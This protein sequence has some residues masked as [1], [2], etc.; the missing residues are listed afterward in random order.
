[1]NVEELSGRLP[2]LAR[3][4][5]VP[6]GQFALHHKGE[7]RSF[8]FGEQDAAG[9]VPVTGDAK[10]PVG[11]ITKAF[12]AALAML[13]VDEGDLD[14]DAPVA[15]VLTEL[16]APDARFGAATT[17]R[18]LLSH[19]GGL[20]PGRDS[21]SL[22]GA[23]RR[24]YLADCARMAPIDTFG[25]S[26]SYSNVGYT[27]IGMLAEQAVRMD[28]REALESFLLDPLDIEPAYIA[29]P[30]A[31]PYVSGHAART[32]P[33]RAVPVRQTLPAIEAPAGALAL[34][35]LDLLAFGLLHT[36][37]ADGVPGLLDADALAGM[38][39]GVPGAE[40]FGLAD[41]WGLGLSLYRADDGTH[42]TGHDGTADGTSC[43]LRVD[44]AGGTVVALTTNAHTGMA[45][46]E[47][48]L[49]DLR[50]L[51]LDVAS[52]SYSA[53]R[54]PREKIPAPPGCLGRYVNGETEYLVGPGGADGNGDEL[55]LRLD[56]EPFA[57]ITV[58]EGL[59]FTLREF[60]EGGMVY[61]GR[62]LRNPATGG[63]DQIQVTGRRAQRV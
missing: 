31:R 26:F 11:S 5:G 16:R 49:A 61:L 14:L 8:V 38:R 51:G 34:S 46:W 17:L 55:T 33:A 20:P 62:F 48:L 29:G 15:E 25:S 35:A 41:G 1:M 27:V 28:W 47:S 59:E 39:A 54:D 22:A 6:G 63:I 40:P 10:F 23:T 19:S 44:P 12:T 42:W 24:G 9:T 45:M 53:F 7:T 58:H 50:Q 52:Y 36:D 30:S 37:D 13:L 43:H 4:H 60:A 32:A 2:A 18:Q 3:E 21:D 57:R 56:G